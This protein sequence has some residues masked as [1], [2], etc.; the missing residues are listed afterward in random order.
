MVVM[1]ERHHDQ[2]DALWRDP[3]PAQVRREPGKVA[4]A[5]SNEILKNV[6]RDVLASIDERSSQAPKPVKKP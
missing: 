2:I 6:Q 1:T 3:G 5:L 4:E